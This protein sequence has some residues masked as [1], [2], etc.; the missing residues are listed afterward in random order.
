M[1]DLLIPSTKILRQRNASN[2]QSNESE[3]LDCKHS[4]PTS[5]SD[6]NSTDNF[7]EL[8][9]LTDRNSGGGRRGR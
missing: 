8:I 2:I 3:R 4:D 1:N 9:G 6:Q 7:S 5:E